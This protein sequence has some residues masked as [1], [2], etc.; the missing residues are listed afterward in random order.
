MLNFH[1]SYLMISLRTSIGQSTM[2]FLHSSHAYSPAKRL[3]R[4]EVKV[5]AG[6][7]TPA[8]SGGKTETAGEKER[9]YTRC[10]SRGRY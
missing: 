3:Q 2:N 10:T 9:E 5:G 6:V 1:I 4:I 8:F 7:S